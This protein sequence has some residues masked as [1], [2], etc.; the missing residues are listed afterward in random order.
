MIPARFLVPK[1]PLGN[2]GLGSSSFPKPAT[3]SWSLPNL[4]PN[5]EVGNQQMQD[6]MPL[7]FERGALEVW[8]VD[9]EGGISFFGPGNQK[10]ERSR[11]IPPAPAS[12]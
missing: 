7:Y 8:I 5:L 6:K 12:I 1:L 2:A 11:L 10:L 3:A 9:T 4:V